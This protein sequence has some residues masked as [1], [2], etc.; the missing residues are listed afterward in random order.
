MFARA[1][2][3][4]TCALSVLRGLFH[5]EHRRTRAGDAV[6]DTESEENPNAGKKIVDWGEDGKPIYEDGSTGGEEAV[7]E[8]APAK[9]AAGVDDSDTNG[10][11]QESFQTHKDSKPNGPTAISLDITFHGAKHVYGL[12]EHATSLALKPTDGSPDAYP[13]PYRWV[14]EPVE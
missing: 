10:M 4:H 12:P 13:Q 2:H 6:G 3:S 5:F 9:P 8:E 14:A 11:W 7:A 1:A